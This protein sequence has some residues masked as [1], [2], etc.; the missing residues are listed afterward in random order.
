MEDKKVEKD[1]EVATEM[2]KVDVRCMN[3]VVRLGTFYV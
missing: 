3:F 1:K 2:A